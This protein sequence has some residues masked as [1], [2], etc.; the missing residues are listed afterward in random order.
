MQRQRQRDIPCPD[1]L[2]K[3]LQQFGMGQAKSRSQKLN[4]SFQGGHR[5]SSLAPSHRA[6]VVSWNGE[7]R[8]CLNLNLL[9]TYVGIPSRGLMVCANC[10][11]PYLH[12]HI[13]G[14]TVFCF[15]LYILI[16]GY[17]Y[18]NFCSLSLWQLLLYPSFI[19]HLWIH[20]F[21]KLKSSITFDVSALSIIT[22]QK[23][24]S[25]CSLMNSSL[26][27]ISF[28]TSALFYISMYSYY[29]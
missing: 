17:Q 7:W 13:A 24:L 29:L 26:F 4:Q 8:Q 1:W 15:F 18:F 19:V 20:R 27:T 16:I 21:D 14:F 12:K 25:M 9:M 11:P 28:Q 22:K 5:V 23:T 10:L 2:A 6:W 3:W